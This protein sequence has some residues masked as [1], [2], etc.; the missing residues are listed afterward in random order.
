MDIFLILI[1]FR[2]TGVPRAAVARA[3]PGL[4]EAAVLGG[5]G[6][7][8][9]AGARAQR[10]AA[11]ASAREPARVRVSIHIHTVIWFNKTLRNAKN[12]KI[13]DNILPSKNN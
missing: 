10:A 13:S 2:S 7:H 11:H 4:P 3:V 5:G 9:G 12:I 8:R 6:A 1:Q